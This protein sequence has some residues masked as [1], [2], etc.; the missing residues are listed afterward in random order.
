MTYSPEAHSRSP[1]EPTMA[2][3]IPIPSVHA[4]YTSERSLGGRP[5]LSPSSSRSPTQSSLS[6]YRAHPYPRRHS[7][8]TQASL[9]PREDPSRIYLPPPNSG[10]PLHVLHE[11]HERD[12]RDPRDPREQR[13]PRSPHESH[14][15]RDVRD[16]RDREWRDRRPSLPRAHSERYPGE[17]GFHL[18]SFASISASAH[19]SPI[20]HNTGPLTP[21]SVPSGTMGPPAALPATSPGS[22][23]AASPK[24][25]SLGGLRPSY[26]YDQNNTQPAPSSARSGPTLGLSTQGGGG[27]SSC[28][29]ND[30]SP[31]RSYPPPAD[32]ASPPLR[33]I[34]GYSPET[35]LQ[36]P[37]G[38]RS[39]S[40]SAA[41]ALSRYGARSAG[42]SDGGDWAAP[43]TPRETPQYTPS[44]GHSSG[45][46]GSGGNGGGGQ[47]R[48]LAH[49]M[50]E[51]KR[52][53]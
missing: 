48:R 8:S 37:A 39:R 51:Q 11:R 52:R 12:A 17:R 23:R 18:P 34:N 47:S 35:Y 24:L 31:P 33:A 3:S 26:S 49:L 2:M 53:E 6:S 15:H 13:D 5:L 42:S 22:S 27:G 36:Q 45:G 43:P 46:N 30:P 1:T 19:G 20:Q 50:S 25:F 29:R 40:H 41:S 21:T 38:G 9:S 44:G 4:P 10:A 16:A 14:S 7:V 28:Y 32:R